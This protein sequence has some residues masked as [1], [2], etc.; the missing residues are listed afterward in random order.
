MRSLVAAARERSPTRFRHSAKLLR[1]LTA[2]DVALTP[3]ELAIPSF[4]AHLLKGELSG[5]W[6]IWVNDAWRVTFRFV[7][8]DV[9]LFG[10]QDY[11]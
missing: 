3:D 10:Y 7:D 8:S 9:E 4:R 11:H 5:H 1:I 6:S 2:L